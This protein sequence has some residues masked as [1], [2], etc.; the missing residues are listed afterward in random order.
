MKRDEAVRLRPDARVLFVRLSALGDMVF[1]LPA[2]QA[3]R[4]HL[5]QVRVDWLVED[6]HAAF[7]AGH[8]GVDEVIVFPRAS[9]KRAHGLGRLGA[10]G[11]VSDHLLGLRR[12]N[13]YDA[14]LDFQGNLKSALHLLFCRSRLKVGFDRPVSR[15]GAHH[16]LNIKIPDPGRVHRSVRDLELVRALGY[17]GPLPHPAPWDLPRE[18]ETEVAR[19][20]EHPL[21]VPERAQESGPLILLHTGVTHYGRDK[22]WGEERWLPLARELSGRFG[23]RA[24]ALWSPS[25]RG[26]VLQRCRA[27]EGF[28][29]LAPPTPTLNHLMALTDRAAL[30][31]GTD[32]GPLHLAAYRGTPV[33]ALFGPTDPLR[34]RPP[35]RNVQVVSAL[36]EG[37]PPP[38]GVAT[39]PLP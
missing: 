36:P 18:V 13:P 14:V 12:R 26:E 34:Y 8:P 23:A 28:L 7:P 21:S 16:F 35:G 15:E 22:D 39:A 10:I 31:I 37:Q 4:H 30:L 20:L 1:A 2:L 27:S 38:P 6:R 25:D 24:L 29:G 5:P 11:R 17:A 33:V 9:W 19:S 32:S 3:L